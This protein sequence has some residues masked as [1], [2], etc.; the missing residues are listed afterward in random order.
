[1][2]EKAVKNFAIIGVAGYIAP[3]HLQAIKATG[4]RLVAATDPHDSVG[5]MDRYFLDVAF[6]KEFER[7]DRHIEKLRRGPKEGWV[8]FVTIC[9][10]NYLHDAHARFALRVGADAICEK[11]LVLNPWNL[12]ALEELE[13]EAGKKI[14]TVLQLRLHPAVQALKRQIAA[15][16]P[17]R[18]KVELSYITSRGRWYLYSWKGQPEQSGGLVTNIGIHF[19]DMLIWLFGGVRELGVRV[20]EPRRTEGHLELEHATVDWRL[21]IDAADLPD[22]CLQKGQTMYRSIRI[23]GEELEFSTGFA[24]LHTA[25]YEEILAG[26]GFGIRDALPSIQLVHDIRNRRPTG[27]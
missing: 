25:V 15:E 22:A 4:N 17:R 3:R 13:K 9:S 19:F 27:K 5:I 20:A 26:R 10:P 1:M 6:F 21:S 16:S 7:F 12:E 2:S 14:Y 23:D 18:H 11:P 8:D 24:D